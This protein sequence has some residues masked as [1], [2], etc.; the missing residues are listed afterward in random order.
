MSSPSETL[1]FISALFAEKREDWLIEIRPISKPRIPSLAPRAFPLAQKQAAID[2]SSRCSERGAD[3]YFGV[4][5]RSRW[6]EVR[7]R[8]GGRAEVDFLVALWADLDPPK[9]ELLSMEDARDQLRAVALPPSA[10]VISG[11]GLHAYWFLTDALFV[12]DQAAERKAKLLLKRLAKAVGGDP[13]VADVARV[14]RMPGTANQKP[15]R[16]DPQAKPLP[17]YLR[18]LHT[19]RRYCLEELEKYLPPAPVEEVV[20]PPRPEPRGDHLE[21]ILASNPMPLVAEKLGLG[22]G[23]GNPPLCPC[24]FHDDRDPSLA[25][26]SDHGHC[27][28]C[29]WHGDQI[30]LV[31]RLGPTGF[32]EAVALLASW[33]NLP[34]LSVRRA[35]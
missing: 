5:P 32:R 18:E 6:P 16:K 12:G 31:R 24:P 30:D 2:F 23:R 35:V 34:P 17:C 7:G 11:H 1:Q 15:R 3:V 29:E 22:I 9:G 33:A 21:R 4:A 28:G 14:M 27:F 20:V 13:N 19:D 8:A 10:A 25:L 26:Y